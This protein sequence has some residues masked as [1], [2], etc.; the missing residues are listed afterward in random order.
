MEHYGRAS[1]GFSIE[2]EFQAALSVVQQKI[3]AS[4]GSLTATPTGT[5]LQNEYDDL[6]DMAR[7]LMV[8]NLPFVV[9]QP[10]ELREA[11]LRLAEKMVQMATA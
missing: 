8:L 1:G 3:P 4:Y 6:D 5:L 2:V 9:H 10:P 11:L 7:Y